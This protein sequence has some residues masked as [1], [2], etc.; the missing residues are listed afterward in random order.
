[1]EVAYLKLKTAHNLYGRGPAALAPAEHS[2]VEQM[3]A[4]QFD[5]ESL[6]LA[7][8]EARDVAVP[9][10]TLNAALADIQGRYPSE[11]ALL[12]DLA[13]NGLDLASFGAALERELK[14]EAVL[15]RVG[16]RAAKVSDIDVE[17]YYHY[18]PEQFQRP[19]TRI[20]RHI[21]VT[22]N[23]EL[24]D[25]SRAAARSRIDAIAARLLKEPARFEEQ[26]LKHSECPTALQGGLL[27]EVKRGLLYAELDTALFELEAM[28]LSPVVESPLGLHLLRCDQLIPA[29]MLALDLVSDSIR[30]FLM[31]RRKRV[32][33]NAWLKQI[34]S[35]SSGL[36]TGP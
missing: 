2:R 36:I 34:R 23:E 31:S 29:G 3:A 33:Q 1:M 4:R 13:G 21:L 6:V 28:Q 8:E 20:A 25:N 11:E 27:G 22:I 16:S 10:A 17:L 18:H 24:P 12:D 9:S 19:Q 15:D 35:H 30:E 7:T 14:V 5:L 32:W 26:A